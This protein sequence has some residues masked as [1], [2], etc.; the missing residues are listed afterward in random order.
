MAVLLDTSVL[1]AKVNERDRHHDEANAFLRR[2]LQGEFGTAI[3]TSFVVDEA[4]T[5][6]QFRG[7]PADGARKLGSLLGLDDASPG[8]PFH[9]VSVQD[10]DLEPAY[11]RFLQHYE[12]GLS[13]TDCTL[14][15]VADRLDVDAV[16]TFDS[17]FE[18]LV[19]VVP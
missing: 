2:V 7:Q 10:G 6:M 11:R 8:S 16:A 4:L 5:L 13:F 14:L 3:I 12:R 19:P 18:G 1:F 9:V 15:A 17:D